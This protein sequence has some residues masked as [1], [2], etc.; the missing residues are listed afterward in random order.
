M[1]PEHGARRTSRNDGGDA[2]CRGFTAGPEHGGAP[3]AREAAATPGRSYTEPWRPVPDSGQTRR[4]TVA[5]ARAG[6][7]VC[8]RGPGSCVLLG[9]SQRVKHSSRSRGC[10]GVLTSQLLAPILRSNGQRQ[11]QQQ[12]S[13][14][15]SKAMGGELFQ[16]GEPRPSCRQSRQAEAKTQSCR[17]REP[18][19]GAASPFPFPVQKGAPIRRSYDSIR[20]QDKLAYVWKPAEW[21]RNLSFGQQPTESNFWEEEPARRIAAFVS[22]PHPKSC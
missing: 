19:V 11:H 14:P 20:H 3:R 8:S 5:R 2:R 10:W 7:R 1:P 18:I 4:T 22:I 21:K 6:A 9:G 16:G 12:S 13:R 15:A 17:Q